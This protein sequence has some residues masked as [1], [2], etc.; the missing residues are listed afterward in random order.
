MERKFFMTA[1]QTRK[2]GI[3]KRTH[4]ACLRL[5][6]VCRPGKTAKDASRKGK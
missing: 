4:E 6:G 5:T 1:D 3:V 2:M